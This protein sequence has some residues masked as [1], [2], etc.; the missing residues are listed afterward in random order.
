MTVLSKAGRFVN[1]HKKLLRVIRCLLF[2]MAVLAGYMAYNLFTLPGNMPSKYKSTLIED[3]YA[4]DPAG[5]NRWVR[6]EERRISEKWLPIGSKASE[7]LYYLFG[8][9]FEAVNFNIKKNGREA[10]IILKKRSSTNLFA[11]H[12][13]TVRLYVKG[14]EITYS[15]VEVRIRY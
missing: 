15:A 3:L 1:G 13:F 7:A 6:A 9:G 10:S 12:D 8:L 14:S 11:T 5:Y 2:L 4:I